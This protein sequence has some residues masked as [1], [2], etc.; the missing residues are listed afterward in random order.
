MNY[1]S[2]K[3]TILFCVIVPIIA[4]IFNMEAVWICLWLT[5]EIFIVMAFSHAAI[6]TESDRAIHRQ[7]WDSYDNAFTEHDYEIVYRSS[8][9]Y[10]RR[11]H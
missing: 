6:C 7:Y 10:S 1:L 4:T 2:R 9:L 11:G 3:D 8:M 5:I